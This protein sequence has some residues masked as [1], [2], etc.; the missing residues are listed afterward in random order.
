MS[1][2]LSAFPF[3]RST[4]YPEARRCICVCRNSLVVL[5]QNEA[6]GKK[7]SDDWLASRVDQ[8]NSIVQVII[9]VLLNTSIAAECICL[10]LLSGSV[11]FKLFIHLGLFLFLPYVC[12]AYVYKPHLLSIYYFFFERMT[13][14]HRCYDCCRSTS[15]TGQPRVH[16]SSI[17]GSDDGSSLHHI[18]A[19]VIV[20]P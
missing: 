15:T 19:A 1:V 2:C 5:Q 3:V 8:L 12:I 14:M 16:S 18:Y 9:T 7:E 17:V 13:Y 4:T 20:M 10:A 6:R 11:L